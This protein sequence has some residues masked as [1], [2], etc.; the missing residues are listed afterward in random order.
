MDTQAT[1]CIGKVV[2]V[3]ITAKYAYVVSEAYNTSLADVYKTKKLED[4]EFT[5]EHLTS[6]AYS[7]L[8]ACSEHHF[9][10]M[11]RM[12][13][14]HFSDQVS[15]ILS[16]ITLFSFFN[17]I[18]RFFFYAGS[19]K[20]CWAFFYHIQPIQAKASRPLVLGSWAAL[21]LTTVWCKWLVDRWHNPPALHVAAIWPWAKRKRI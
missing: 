2:Q 5:E 21:K 7:L 17:S 18:N 10:C 4:T 1:K 12:E 8:T 6:I 15:Q 3:E 13:M 19:N 11:L 16:L 14:V 9:K 20:S